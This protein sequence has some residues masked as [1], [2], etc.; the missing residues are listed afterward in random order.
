MSCR[1]RRKSSFRLP[2]RCVMPIHVLL[3]KRA[4]SLAALRFTVRRIL[5]FGAFILLLSSFHSSADGQSSASLN[6]DGLGKVAA[7][8]GDASPNAHSLAEPNSDTL[9]APSEDS[10][11]KNKTQV[12]GFSIGSETL[13]T[14]ERDYGIAG[15]ERVDEWVSLV[16]EDA[17]R[18]VLLEKLK[19]A[20]DFF[21]Q[22]RWLTDIEHWGQDDYW[23]TPVQTLASNGGDCEDF[24]IGKYFSLDYADFDTERLR[25]TYVKSL[26]YNQAHMVLSYYETPGAEPLILDNIEKTILPASQRDDLLPIYSFDVRNIWL[27]KAR[28]KKLQADSMQSLPKWRGVNERMQLESMQRELTQ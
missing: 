18:D 22:V 3:V 12:S 28:G 25:I 19:R 5:F 16:R 20:N 11:V 7:E 13:A 2:H 17:Q 6:T 1:S 23:A 24:S 9:A 15:R 27:A 21:N 14:V 4:N 10:L 26:T 8:V